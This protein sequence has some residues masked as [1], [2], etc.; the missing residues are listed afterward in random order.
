MF[1]D[2]RAFSNTL[3]QNGSTLTLA[4]FNNLLILLASIFFYNNFNKFSFSIHLIYHHVKLKQHM[5][6]LIHFHFNLRRV[7]C[8]LLLLP[9]LN[10]I[11]DFYFQK[12]SQKH[13]KSE[14]NKY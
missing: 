9:Y 7:C 3:A 12:Y 1:L 14:K 5:C 8:L 13:T 11:K 6:M 2:L 4:A 10:F